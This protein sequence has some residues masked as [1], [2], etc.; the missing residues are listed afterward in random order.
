MT[1]SEET[2]TNRERGDTERIKIQ[3]DNTETECTEKK[4]RTQRETKETRNQSL[5]RVIGLRLIQ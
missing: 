5:T 3:R 2:G 1:E 4:K